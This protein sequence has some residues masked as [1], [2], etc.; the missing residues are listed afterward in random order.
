MTLFSFVL[1]SLFAGF[2][3]GE[4]RGYAHGARDEAMRYLN[5]KF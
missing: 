2:C 5:E 1:F 4:H 3:V